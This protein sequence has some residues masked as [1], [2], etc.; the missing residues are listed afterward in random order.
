MVKLF[1]FAFLAFIVY[2][3]ASGCYYLLTDKSQGDRVVRALSWRI[4]AS[5]VLVALIGLGIYAGVIEPHGLQ[6]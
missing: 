4:G 1:I 6:R 5:L 3:L 2:S